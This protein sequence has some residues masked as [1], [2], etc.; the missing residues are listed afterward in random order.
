[1]TNTR[2]SK[3]QFTEKE[4]MSIIALFI[5]WSLCLPLSAPDNTE[6]LKDMLQGHSPLIQRLILERTLKSNHPSLAVGNKL[7][8]QVS[9]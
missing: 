6:E 4:V 2:C 1:M 3:V 8:L 7:K 5:S 9:V